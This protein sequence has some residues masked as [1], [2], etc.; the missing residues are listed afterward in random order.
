MRLN[1]MKTKRPY[2]SM[3][4]IMAVSILFFLTFSLRAQTLTETDGLYDIVKDEDNVIHNR[5]N[6]ELLFEKLYKIKTSGRGNVNILH[7]GDSHIQAD[8]ITE[9]V[10]RNLQYEF[11]NAGRGFIFPGRVAGTN[12]PFNIRTSSQDKWQVKKVIHIQQPLPV[13]LGGITLRTEQAGAKINIKMMDA[14]MDYSFNTLTLFYQKDNDSYAFSFYDSASS[15][16]ASMA[17][18]DNDTGK[19]HSS[20]TLP[21]SLNQIALHTKKNAD[22][23]KQ[24]VL[25]GVSLTNGRSGVLYHAIGV[26]GAKYLHYNAAKYFAEQTSILQPDLIVISMGTNESVGYPTLDP[27]FPTHINSLVVALRNY[28]SEAAILLVSPADAFQ[29][30]IKHNPGIEIVR[31]QIIQYA[32]ENGLAFWDMFKVNGGQF[33]ANAWRTS[34]LLRPDG[35]HFTKAGYAYQGQLFYEAI[36]KGYNEYVF[37]RY[38]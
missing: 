5:V 7:I 25:F 3:R 27:K 38:P 32:V 8:F 2:N 1:V 23:Q 14:A 17:F 33:S 20:V 29:K 34:G 16:I 15:E 22:Q 26:N 31:D 11:G 24:A 12:E 36:M 10:R 30:K 35:I 19:F 21:T 28:N 13:G 6:L 18:P 9:V 37:S 4:N